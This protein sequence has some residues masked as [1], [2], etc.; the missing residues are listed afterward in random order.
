[1]T[2]GTK[3]R[4]LRSIKGYSQENMAAM[5]GLSLNSYSKIERDEVNITVKRLEEIALILKMTIVDILTFEDISIT[6]TKTNVPVN[7][8][9]KFIR[10]MMELERI[11]KENEWFKQEINQLRIIIQTK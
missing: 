7:N 8:N 9:M 5:L 4:N 11:N 2:L 3:I 1:M 10:I 6:L